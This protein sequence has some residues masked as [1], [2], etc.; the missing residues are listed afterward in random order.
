MLRRA[1]GIVGFVLGTWEI[2]RFSEDSRAIELVYRLAYDQEIFQA[3]NGSYRD[4]QGEE[5]GFRYVSGA[6]RDS[7]GA[8]YWIAMQAD[9]Q[10]LFRSTGTGLVQIEPR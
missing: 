3:E 1:F 7:S 4:L 5:E 8:W 2:P 10:Y 6:G 9:R